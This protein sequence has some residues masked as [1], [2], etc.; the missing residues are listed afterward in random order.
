MEYQDNIFTY[1]KWRGD[2]LIKDYPLNEVDALILSELSYIDFAHI[3]PGVGEEGS[4]TIRE[5]N[6]KYEKK[7]GPKMI[8]FEEKEE[9]F[10][11]LAESPR[12]ADLTL[13]NY[14]STLDVKEHHQFAAMHVNI[15]PILTF[16]VFR[17]TDSTVTG[18]REDFNMSYMMPV[19][20]Q[21]SAV[22]YVNQTAKGMFKKF[23]LGGHSKGGNLAIYSG[24]FCNP[25]VQK[26]IV[27]IYS[28]DGPG[29]NRK[30]VD[31]EAYK[32]IED[33]IE[34]FVPEGSVVGMLMEHEEDYKVIKSTESALMQ[35]E[36]F[37]WVVDSDKFSQ[38]D[39]RNEFSKNF[40]VSVE[41]WIADMNPQ[42]RKDVVDAFFDVFANAGIDDFVKIVNM[43]MK[44]AGALLRGVTK[45]PQGQRDQVGKLIKI[46]IDKKK[47]LD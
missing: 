30:M 14:V 26:K 39:D 3:V 13:S 24:V 43:D 10:D 38:A 9:L 2:L 21:Q 40:S 33:R 11:K 35:H 45:V 29:F 46:L 1:L 31:D 5:A 12:F 34:A 27:K 6:E 23:Y 15:S 8:F 25:K 41:T 17:G 16:I 37:S 36:G 20:A 19:P 7:P 22:D 28:F 32:M 42:E 44:T 4:I 47:S 18:W